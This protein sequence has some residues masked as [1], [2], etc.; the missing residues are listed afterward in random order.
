VFYWYVIAAVKTDGSEV[1]S[2]KA[3]ARTTARAVTLHQNHPNPFNPTT[4][5]AFAL[6]EKA[7]ADVSIFN[8]EGRFVTT[9]LRGIQNEGTTEVKWDGTDA[10]GNPA[11]SGVYFCRLQT[12]KLNVTKKMVLLK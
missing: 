12:G 1:R 2:L 11:A 3:S 7:F 4:T 10:V 9:V 5:I 6:P 8:I